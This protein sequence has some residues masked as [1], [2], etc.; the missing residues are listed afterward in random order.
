MSGRRFEH[1]LLLL[2]LRKI[3]RSVGRGALRRGF[4]S[5]SP[6]AHL[7]RTRQRKTRTDADGVGLHE[8]CV[9]LMGHEE[10]SVQRCGLTESREGREKGAAY[11]PAA[12]RALMMGGIPEGTLGRAM[13]IAN[14]RESHKC[15]KKP[16]YFM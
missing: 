5:C 14:R 2:L 15:P 16:R 9:A 10:C 11:D 4:V 1:A 13:G 12:R 6:T 8:C 7:S 3:G